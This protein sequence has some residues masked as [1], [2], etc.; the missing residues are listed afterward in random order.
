MRCPN[1]SAPASRSPGTPPIVLLKGIT[2][3]FPGVVANQDV[4]LDVMPGEIH[5]L[6]GEN[7]AGKSTL[8]NI[9]TGIYQPDA[10]EII[11]DGYARTLRL[12][13][14]CDRRRHRHGPPALQA[15]AGLHGR[16]EHPSRL[17]RD[18]A[19]ASASR[20]WRRERRR[21]PRTFNLAVDPGAR[22]ADL[23]DRRA[24]AGGDPARARAQRARADPRRAD[25]GADAG[26]GAA[27]CSRRCS[28]FARAATRSSSSATSST[29]CSRSPTASPCCAAAAR[30]RP[31]RPPIATRRCSRALMVG[32]EIVL[33]DMRSRAPG[34]APVSTEP[35][36]SLRRRHRAATSLG[37]R[38][39]D[40]VIARPPCRRDSRHRRRRRQRPARAERGPDRHPRRS[41]PAR[42]WSTARPFRRPAPRPSPTSASAISRR[43]G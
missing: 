27:S 13:D 2:K 29:R 41:P 35:V 42:S 23:S 31:R 39:L 28:D 43:T 14:R 34:A 18:A 24:A 38:L 16:R 37:S 17:G 22:V 8:M 4:D 1:P 12:A 6:L 19:R 10:G 5:A 30:S 7:G 32:R 9:L 26:R 21:S 36:L 25:R 33:G 3:Y 40:N 20:S 11:I 15:G